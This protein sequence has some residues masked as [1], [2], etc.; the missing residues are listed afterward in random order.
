MTDRFT[1]GPWS[2]DVDGYDNEDIIKIIPHEVYGDFPICNLGSV[3]NEGKEDCKDDAERIWADAYLIA[4]APELLEAL[5]DMVS[6]H[7]CLNKATLEF[8][9]KTIEKATGKAGA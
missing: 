8:A 6:D 4:A 9:R 7:Q 5:R 2:V 3:D 1:P